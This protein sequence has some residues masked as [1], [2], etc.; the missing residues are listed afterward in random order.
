M[1]V[2]SNYEIDK[3]KVRTF[4]NFLWK[5][6]PGCLLPVDPA[7]QKPYYSDEIKTVFRLSSKSHWDVPIKVDDKTIHFLTAHPTPPVFDG[8]EDRNGRRNHD[9]IR[10][11][12][13]YV[14]PERSQYIYDDQGKTGGLLQDQ[15]FVIAG[16]MNADPNDGDSTMNAAK[17]LT[18]HILINHSKTPAS[19]G[20]KYYSK[21][22]GKAN[23]NH[24]GNPVFDTGDF[25]D[26]N[27]GNLRIDY[28][29]PS[30]KLEIKQSGVFW[31]KPGEPGA[32]LVTASDHRMIWVDIA[33]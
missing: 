26:A 24:K 23:L 27:V 30:R 8:K 10:F 20:G 1:V 16:D 9:E 2:L 13:D 15:H 22:Q 5:D 29:L 25:S 14:T 12:A 17:L 18:E 28:C 7:T 19:E 33:K 6:M 3:D 21:E 31:P 4:Q 11:F 32:D